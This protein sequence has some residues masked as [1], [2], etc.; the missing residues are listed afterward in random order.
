MKHMPLPQVTPQQ[1]LLKDLLNRGF[2]LFQG[3][4]N[5]NKP[6]RFIPGVPKGT[7]YSLPSDLWITQESELPTVYDKALDAKV[8]VAPQYPMIL[9]GPLCNNIVAIDID[10]REHEQFV[11]NVELFEA[12]GISEETTYAIRTPGKGLHLY[13]KLKDGITYRRKV[14]LIKD[15]DF[16]GEGGCAA[17]PLCDGYKIIS[18]LPIMDAPDALYKWYTEQTANTITGG[19]GGTFEELSY[20]AIIG[21]TIEHGDRNIILYKMA[22]QM[23]YRLQADDEAEHMLLAWIQSAANNMIPPYTNEEENEPALVRAMV[24]RALEYVRN[25]SQHTQIPQPVIQHDAPPPII[26]LTQYQSQDFINTDNTEYSVIQRL[27]SMSPDHNPR[28]MFRE[29]DEEFWIKERVWKK[30]PQPYTTLQTIFL[31]IAQ[32]ERSNGADVKQNNKLVTKIKSHTSFTTILHALKQSTTLPF[33]SLAPS[34][35]AW[36]GFNNGVLNIHTKEFLSEV[37]E[38][39][40]ATS[41]V[42]Y[43]YEP[44]ATAPAWRRLM[45]S[46]FEGDS[47]TQDFLELLMGYVLLGSNRDKKMFLFIGKADAGKSTLMRAWTELF[48]PVMYRPVDT[49]IFATKKASAVPEATVG[50]SLIPAIEARLVIA[51]EVGVTDILIP[52]DIKRMTGGDE[53]TARYSR[54]KKMVSFTPKF[55]PIMTGND[56]PPFFAAASPALK[57]RLT[58]IPLT[59]TITADMQRADPHIEED[60]VNQLPGLFNLALQ[61][62]HKYLA[63]GKKVNELLSPVIAAATGKFFDDADVFGTFFDEEVVFGKRERTPAHNIK[64]AWTAYQEHFMQGELHKSITMTS[65]SRRLKDV[66]CDRIKSNGKQF[67][68][69]FR[70]KNPSESSNA[71]VLQKNIGMLSKGPIAVTFGD[72]YSTAIAHDNNNQDFLCMP[73]LKAVKTTKPKPNKEKKK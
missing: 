27:K 2:T 1:K 63:S 19:T 51:S 33:D 14:G 47:Q 62:M 73:I 60:L 48:G 3:R 23:A 26:D 4:V 43:N 38:D 16:L 42:D 39:I 71:M 18:E 49:K 36:V 72:E 6:G 54:A 59:K 8:P 11:K 65:L 12:M 20:D 64:A 55:V 17:S 58:K 68:T 67:W 44:E 40:Y 34:A 10:F 37:P 57:I 70:L 46:M 31:L 9:N 25:A 13:I 22:C 5:P 66:G 15:V 69:G 24:P 35:R 45:E 52:E 53:M 7:N 32:Q 56:D 28:M 30:L 50:A 61:G 21:K 41:I 29:T